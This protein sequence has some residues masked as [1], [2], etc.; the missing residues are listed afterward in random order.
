[1]LTQET[2]SFL[3]ERVF[4]SSEL[5]NVP[6]FGQNMFVVQKTHNLHNSIEQVR[7]KLEMLKGKEEFQGDQE[8]QARI[9]DVSWVFRSGFAI[10]KDNV[11]NFKKLFGIL[12][13]IK[14]DGIFDFDFVKNLIDSSWN[15]HKN[16]I[17]HWL[18]YPYLA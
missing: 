8:V 10:D 12:Q 2:V 15:E 4:V 1:M 16:T 3:Q 18:F 7:G 9:L 17:L 5:Q 11:P 14:N 13:S 6:W